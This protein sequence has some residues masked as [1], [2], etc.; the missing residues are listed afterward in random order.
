MLSSISPNEQF[1]GLGK[2]RYSLGIHLFFFVYRSEVIENHGPTRFLMGQIVD[3][4]QT[5]KKQLLCS[6]QLACFQGFEP[7]FVVYI[8]RAP[9]K[10]HILSGQL[11][12]RTSRFCLAAFFCFFRTALLDRLFGVATTYNTDHTERGQSTDRKN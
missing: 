4:A 6:V 8:D 1:L 10:S 7:L 12:W 9:Q 11:F 2:Q 3:L 5:D